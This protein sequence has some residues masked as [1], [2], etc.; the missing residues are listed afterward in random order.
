MKLETA[1][2]IIKQQANYIIGGEF[3]DD[4]DE[5]RLDRDGNNVEYYAV[6]SDY[7]IEHKN[8]DLSKL[9]ITCVDEHGGEGQGSSYGYVFKIDHPEHGVGYIAYEGYY[10]SWN[11]TDWDEDP[12]MVEPK[13]QTI[14]VYEPVK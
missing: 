4:E 6:A 1:L 14:T 7:E 12:F 9:Y 13:E 11:G 3:D 2:E 10:D 8:L 5:G